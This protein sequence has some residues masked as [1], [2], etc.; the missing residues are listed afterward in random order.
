MKSFKVKLPFTKFYAGYLGDQRTDEFTMK[1]EDRFFFKK[2]RFGNLFV[3]Y[4]CIPE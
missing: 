1:I 4:P 3:F 2:F